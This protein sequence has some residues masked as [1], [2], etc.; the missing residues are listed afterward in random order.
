[1][2]IAS[3]RR[4]RVLLLIPHLG[5]GGAERIAA[6]LAQYLSP[7]KY[8]MHLGLV[9][10]SLQAPKDLMPS[11]TVHALGARRVRSGT[12]KLLRLV[13]QVRPA[14]ILSGIAHLNLLVLALRPVFP[15]RTRVFVRQN[16]TLS[17]TLATWRNPRLARSVYAT[18]YRRADMVICQ[19]RQMAEELHRELGVESAKLVVLPNPVDI[20]GIRASVAGTNDALTSPGPHLVA[21]ARLARE[22][23]IDLLLE[24]FARVCRRFPHADLRIAGSGSCKHALLAQ[25]EMLGIE[26][27]VK[28]LG[29]VT[30]PASLF[31][32]TSL[33][34]L[35]SR[36]EGMPNA[37]LEAAA[38]GLPIVALPA[39]RGLV[40]LL[41]SQPGIWI[42]SEIAVRALENALCEA[43]FSLQSGE[44]FRHSWI[45][46]FDLKN[47]IP[48]YEDVI[49]RA[50]QER[51]V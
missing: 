9:T 17:A 44:R 3:T 40:E 38:A 42:A 4:A 46:P 6:T 23:G 39:S 18:A 28:F 15:S 26:E 19:T 27:R 2:I 20:P 36:Q 33:F 29:N 48:A 32:C 45:E 14:V 41:T 49:D 37:L 13:W 30:E 25:C 12:W 35:S 11:N 47:A 50:L 5:G 10:E 31:R 8:E 24:A 43:L 16:G 1:M 34:V 21:V 51:E 7:K 22:K